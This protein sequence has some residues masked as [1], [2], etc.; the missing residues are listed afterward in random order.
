MLVNIVSTFQVPSSYSLSVKMVLKY[1]NKRIT[2]LINEWQKLFEEHYHICVLCNFLA[3]EC[4]TTNTPS[5][6]CRTH[7]SK[8]MND[9]SI[10][11]AK[12]H[13]NCTKVANTSLKERFC[14]PILTFSSALMKGPSSNIE[15]VVFLV[16]WRLYVHKVTSKKIGSL[17]HNGAHSS[18]RFDRPGVA[19]AVLQIPPLLIKLLIK[20][21]IN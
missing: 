13:F 10:S 5:A 1:F 19:G 20:L 21:L 12:K 7:W 3:R 6:P 16:L 11:H 15:S 4:N 9:Q 14:L 2:K 18:T 8:N 17:L